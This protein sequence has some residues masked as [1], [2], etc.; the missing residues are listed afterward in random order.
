LRSA[1]G[2]WSLAPGCSILDE[3]AWTSGRA[4]Q[5][6]SRDEALH[7]SSLFCTHLLLP[8]NRISEARATEMIVEAVEIETNFITEALPCAMLGMNAEAD[9]SIF[10]R[11]GPSAVADGLLKHYNT[12]THSDFMERISLPNKTEFLRRSS[13]RICPSRCKGR[14]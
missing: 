14:S 8:E 3:G 11:S 6:A 4:V 12:V 1:C 9:Y 13:E 7:T 5:D 10:I 2:R